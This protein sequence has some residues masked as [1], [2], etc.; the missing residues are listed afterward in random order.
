MK[1]DLR[2]RAEKTD[3]RETSLHAHV[4]EFLDELRQKTDLVRVGSM[5]RSGEGADMA[6]AIASDRDC[7]T[8]EAAREQRKTIVM[9]QANI[10]AGEVEGKESLLALLRDLTLTKRG[11][12]VLS[13]VCLVAIPDLNPDGNDRIS[14]ENRKLNLQHLEGQINPP[15]GVG[16]R[17]SGQGWNLNRDYVKQDSPE[18][19]N[20]AAL[21]QEWWPHVFVDCHT[22]DGSL[23]AFDMTFDTAHSNQCLFRKLQKPTRKMLESIGKRIEREHGYRSYWYGNFAREDTPGSGWHTYPAL[24]RFGSHYRGLQGRMDVLLETYSYLDFKTRCEVIYA[25]L[26]ELVR[27]AAKQARKIQR[28]VE[29]EEERTKERGR[30]LDPRPQVGVNY[31][32]AG[33]DEKGNLVFTYPAHALGD[34]AS[35]VS[36]DEE[37]VRA[38]RYP[39][40]E[41]V[42]YEGPHKRWFV[43]TYAV[44]TPLAYLAPEFL[45]ERLRGHG[46]E[47]EKL[48][49][50]RTFETESY[51]VLSSEKTFSPDVATTPVPKGGTEIPLS[52]KPAPKRFESVLTVRAER[53]KVEVEAG[54]LLVKTAQRAGTLAVY[55]L[56]P[57]SDDGFARW[58]LLDERIKVGELYPVHRIWSL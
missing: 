37:S 39:G 38:R 45:A 44:S 29:D 51:V 35:V 57:H 3:Y 56:E 46:I 9:I 15:G 8:P 20:L 21:F 34:E 6:I 58:E 49:A 11:R 53:R 18:I 12:K 25:W 1:T 26:D 54:T 50:P 30:A 17:N 47:F 33:R 23:T 52:Q 41:V 27:Y 2:T 10:H 42:T 16:T 19:R 32:V 4:L 7:F 14:P 31:G 40:N 24:P 48:D 36:W 5:G 43:P 55:L 28:V 22:S 13:K